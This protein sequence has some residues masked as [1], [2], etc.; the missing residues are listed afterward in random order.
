MKKSI[1]AVCS[2]IF[3]L[4]VTIMNGRVSAAEMTNAE[5][6]QNNLPDYCY[7]TDLYGN[8]RVIGFFYNSQ[9][10]QFIYDDRDIIEGIQDES[11]SMVAQYEY[12]SNEVVI[13]TYSFENGERRENKEK[14]FIGNINQ[15]L[16]LG[17]IYDTDK[18]CYIIGN[19]NYDPIRK[20]FVDGNTGNQFLTN[21]NPFMEIVS[22]SSI[23]PL[24][25]YYSDIEA[26]EWADALLDSD[27]YG[28]PMSYNSGWYSS[29]SDVEALARTIYCE[30]GTQY[31][32][33]GNAVAW[34]ILNRVKSG[35]FPNAPIDVVKEPYQFTSLTGKSGETSGARNPAQ[36]SDRWKNATYLACLLLTTTSTSEW[37]SLVGNQLNGQLHFYSYTA[38]KNSGNVFSGNSSGALCY[39]STPIK[40]VYVLGYGNVSS[41]SS[42]FSNYNPKEYSRNIYYDKK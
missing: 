8:L 16:W 23:M 36:S 29:L 21:T 20:S 2:I 18:A 3:I 11:G 42:L 26:Q 7:G 27:K 4:C 34:V 38:A 39:G 13:K 24:D 14:S 28:I 31:T 30:G 25:S 37:S 32:T 1:I 17:Y 6:E 19:R 40:N 10:F 22:D 12:D 9:H 15:M 41:F 33:E 5:Y 35:S